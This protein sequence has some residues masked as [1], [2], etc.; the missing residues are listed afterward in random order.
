MVVQNKLED[1]LRASASIQKALLRFSDKNGQGNLHVNVAVGDNNYIN[2]IVTDQLPSKMRLS[3]KKVHLVQKYHDD[4]FF[5]AGCICRESQNT[6]R[7]FSLAI[8][9]ATWF[10]RKRKGNVTW[11]H[12]KCTFEDQE[13][14]NAA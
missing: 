7:V 1:I 4:Y 10:I 12:E 5:I 8:I 6:S 2:C 11:L 9:K 3:G 13:K 14:I